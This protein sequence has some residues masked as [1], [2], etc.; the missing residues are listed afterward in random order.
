MDKGGMVDVQRLDTLKIPIDTITFHYSE[1]LFTVPVS[2]IFK[3]KS[4]YAGIGANISYHYL[5]KATSDDYPT[6]KDYEPLYMY[7]YGAQFLLGFEKP[8]A[9][10]VL[11]SFESNLNFVWLRDYWI[12]TYGLGVGVKY[13]FDN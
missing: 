5:M 11:I 8:I 4:V 6:I 1:Y 10:N 3:Y 2:L 13:V 12:P 7:L 9:K